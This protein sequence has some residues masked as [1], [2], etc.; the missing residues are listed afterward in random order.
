MKNSQKIEPE[1]SLESL[2]NNYIG[3][4]KCFYS[5]KKRHTKAK[6]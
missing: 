2:K 5:G 4:N 1:I 6:K 3:G